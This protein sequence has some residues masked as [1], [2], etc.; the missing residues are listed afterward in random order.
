MEVLLACGP[1]TGHGGMKPEK[2]L[3]PLHLQ[4]DETDWAG[5]FGRASDRW[6]EAQKEKKHEMIK[7]RPSCNMYNNVTSDDD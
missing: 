2:A 3:E 5:M 4:R 1:R 6:C 7:I